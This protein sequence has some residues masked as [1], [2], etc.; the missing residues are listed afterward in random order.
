VL[1]LALEN[2]NADFKI[3]PS[4]SFPGVARRLAVIRV[5][6]R[7]TRASARRRRIGEIL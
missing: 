4:L 3:A 1:P 2:R 7:T 6:R 5:C